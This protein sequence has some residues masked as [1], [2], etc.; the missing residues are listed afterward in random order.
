MFSIEPRSSKWHSATFVI[1]ETVGR[2]KL[3]RPEICPKP[4]MP[5]STT[6]KSLSAEASNTV[7][8]TPSS[9]F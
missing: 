3:T 4:R 2:T 6:V 1:T 7:R 8:G 9:L 5:I